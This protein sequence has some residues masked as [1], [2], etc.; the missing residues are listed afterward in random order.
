MRINK[1]STIN[2]TNLQNRK[3][4]SEKS[5]QTFKT[6]NLAVNFKRGEYATVFKEALEVDFQKN[7]DIVAK[8]F[9]K[10][11]FSAMC[12]KWVDKYSKVL[13]PTFMSWGLD[14]V[15]KTEAYEAENAIEASCYRSPLVTILSGRIR[16]NNPDKTFPA[17]EFWSDKNSLNVLRPSDYH[18]F[19]RNH[20]IKEYLE[21]SNSGDVIKR[22]YYNSDGTP[23]FWKNFIFG[24]T[25]MQGY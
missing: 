8:T 20:N 16:F 24:D 21:Y 22:E 4:K 7:Y 5:S 9:S 18:A 19:H 2:G 23:S 1:I 17:I 14:E 25:E 15:R 11:G 3:A 10:L 12:E 13:N 6:T